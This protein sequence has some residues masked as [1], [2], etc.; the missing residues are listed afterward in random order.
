MI[1]LDEALLV[2]YGYNMNAKNVLPMVH[3]D[4]NDNTT[5]EFPEGPDVP[6][7]VGE[8]MVVAHLE[9]TLGE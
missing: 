3:I 5:Y 9:L 8:S 7:M 1:Q 2:L 4:G 6:V